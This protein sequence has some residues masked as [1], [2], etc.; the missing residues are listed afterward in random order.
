MNKIWNFLKRIMAGLL[1]F[2]LI[3]AGLIYTAGLS[4]RSRLVHQNPP[5]GQLTDVGGYNMH[6]YCTGQGSPTVILEAGL[7]DFFVSWSKVQPEIAGVTRVCSYDRA[8]LGWSEASPHPR[9]SDVMVEELHSLLVKSSIEGPY[10]LVGQSF[11]GILMRQFAQK[12]PEEVSGIVLVD[13]AHE[14]QVRRLPSLAATAEQFV[15]QF[16]TLSAVSSLGLMALSPAAIPNRGFSDEAYRQ[17]QAVLATTAYFDGAIAES[18]AFYSSALGFPESIGEVPL[19]VLSHGLS[20][21]GQVQF[22]QEW[23]GMQQELADLSSNG[24]QVIAEESGHYIQLDQPGLVIEAILEMAG[25]DAGFLN[26]S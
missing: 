3:L 7:N 25:L 14:Q 17:Y 26:N 18:T 5:P 10:I 6:I 1:I 15:D 16:R 4:A 8:G 21:A 23:T 22:E 11:G 13:S 19:I 12:Y 24:K 9:G 2:I 20:D